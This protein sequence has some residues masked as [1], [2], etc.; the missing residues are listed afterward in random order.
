MIRDV[1]PVALVA[2]GIALGRGLGDVLVAAVGRDSALALVSVAACLAAM[3]HAP[4]W[5]R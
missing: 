1:A 3:A 4:A 2:A 5:R